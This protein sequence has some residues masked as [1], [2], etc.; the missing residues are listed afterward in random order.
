MRPL[1][2][3]PIIAAGFCCLAARIAPAVP[4]EVDW[5]ASYNGPASYWESVNDA[6]VRDGSLY[7]VGFAT[8]EFQRRGY[9]TVK[10][11]PDGA[12]AW[13][14]I[15]EGP[16]PSNTS[17]GSTAFAVAV[18]ESGNVYVTGYSSEESKTD[19]P[20][21]DA[22][23]LKYSPEGNLLWE[24]RYRGS[25]GNVQPSAI[26]LDPAGFVYV[27]GGTWINGG[28]DVFLL[29]YDLDGSLI[30]S[31]SRGQQGQRWDN[32][33]AMALAENGDIV[34]GGYTQPGLLTDLDVYILKYAGD[35]SLR[36]EWTLQGTADVEE[37]IDL[38]VDGDGNTYALA[39]FAPPGSFIGLLTVKLSPT[40]NLLWSDIYSGQSTGDYGAGIALA[41]DGNVF[42]AGAAWENGSQNAMTLLK[43]TSGGQLLWSQSERGGYYSAEC[44]DLAVDSEGAAYVSGF[45][46]N[47]NNQED[48]LTAKF[49]GAGDLIWVTS[50]SAPEAR[51]DYAY[52][53][54]VEENGRVYVIGDAWRGFDRYYDITSVAYR[55]GE[56]SG[57]GTPA[58]QPG[59]IVGGAPR[60]AA[61]P[62]PTRGEAVLELYLPEPN[63]LRLN[64]YDATGR[65][66]RKLFDGKAGRGVLHLAW[67]GR[68]D[69]GEGVVPGVYFIRLA[70]P[71]QT[72]VNRITR[73]E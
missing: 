71:T 37:V 26:M 2:L 20:Y 3:S 52:Q 14:R 28:F 57:I 18:D 25:G 35:G 54:R 21:V 39:Q 70:T 8:V 61:H 30:W 63:E 11:A 10:Y 15:Y 59:L 38:T 32:A 45:A 12:E 72:A 9:I 29:K 5:T 51:S 58:D 62:N 46:F 56:T 34:L 55:Q 44:N 17:P 67:D 41:P 42:V 24:Q 33:F 36:W 60:L 22:A 48:Y 43:Y 49:G 47:E 65:L 40:G 1:R 6:T 13:S 7:V 19:I 69:R 16:T 50:F 31:R 68:S 27:A 53:V 64:I 73:L 66:V 23:T 4:P